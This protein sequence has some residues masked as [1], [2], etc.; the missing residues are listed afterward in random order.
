MTAWWEWYL[1]YLFVF[2][3]IPEG[4]NSVQALGFTHG[5]LDVECTDILPVLF[6]KR[7]QEVDGQMNILHQFLL[8]HLHMAHGNGQTQHLRGTAESS[9]AERFYYQILT[10]AM[11]WLSNACALLLQIQN[12][13]I[14][15]YYNCVSWIVS[16]NIIIEESLSLKFI[17][18]FA[19]YGLKQVT[20][21]YEQ[22]FVWI[23]NTV[24]TA[25]LW[26]FLQCSKHATVWS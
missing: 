4:N 20:T 6:Q 15:H 3:N 25:L 10:K 24:C 16:F 1:F 21:M 17:P 2:L 9:S 26:M 23:M 8:T 22:M 5:A 11:L 14:P 13:K 18:M 12:R 19:F 7:D